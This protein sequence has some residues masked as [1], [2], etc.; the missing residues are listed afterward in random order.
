MSALRTAWCA[1][2]VLALSAV[3]TAAPVPVKVDYRK[4]A[5]PPKAARYKKEFDSSLE[6][7]LRG[8][9]LAALRQDGRAYL[10]VFAFD[11]FGQ[12]GLP[13]AGLLP[14][15]LKTFRDKFL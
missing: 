15:D 11:G 7:I 13:I 2:A 8:R 1:V 10:A 4:T 14:T 3:S 9:D 6:D 12:G 5:L